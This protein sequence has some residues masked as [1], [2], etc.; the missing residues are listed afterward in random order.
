MTTKQTLD[1]LRAH[2]SRNVLFLEP[3]GSWPI[4]WERARGVHVWDAEGRKYLD[5]TAAF[6]VAAAGHANPCVV[7]AGQRQMA[8]LLHAMGDVH[9]HALKARLARELSRITFERW[10]R[11]RAKGKR[12]TAKVA[13]ATGKVIFCNSGFEAVEAALK[14]AVLATG[15]RG[16]IAFE[17]AYHGLGYGALN[18]T[19]REHFRGPFRSQLGEFGHFV[20][21]PGERSALKE[22]A[23]NITKLFRRHKTGA[24]LVEPIQARGGCNILPTGFLPL[25]R[26]LCDRHGALLILDE[27]YTGFG[28]TGKWFACE[29]SGVVP[30]LIC[31]G[32]ALTGG[33]P[34]S[35]CV[36]RADVMDAAWPPS[37]GEAIHTS[38]FLGHPVG[39]AMALAQMEEIK[40]L[41]LCARSA[42][43]G[44]VLLAKLRSIQNSKLKTQ[45]SAR[46]LGLM[47]GLELRRADGSPAS[48]E[49]M[50]VIKAMLHR[51]FI[52]LPE[53]AHG[54]VISFTPP[55]TITEAQLRATVKA[56]AEVLATD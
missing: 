30:D 11:A 27:I 7:R 16:V 48:A 29:H 45:N 37:S 41:K 54:N 52:L 14:T 28:R 40:R 21:F 43:L 24:I 31:L 51:G 32:K 23:Q 56:L 46:A 12:Q 10:G 18:A 20:R 25:L 50:H 4:V 34:L 9:P 26:K 44:K 3:D 36:G 17:G 38:T 33:F 1:L 5:L 53:G 8:T 39:C 47:A 19:H 22:V 15:R 2:E 55:L 6:G 42:R 49:T 13:A 35:A